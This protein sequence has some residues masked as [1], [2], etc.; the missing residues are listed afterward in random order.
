MLRGS[1][2]G[3]PE[4]LQLELCVP[5]GWSAFAYAAGRLCPSTNDY[6]TAT[7]GCPPLQT[8]RVAGLFTAG[9]QWQPGPYEGGRRPGIGGGLQRRPACSPP[10]A[11]AFPPREGSYIGT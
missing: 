5:C 4:R 8:K 2:T 11:G 9:N 7:S 10:A 3:L 6:T 1:H